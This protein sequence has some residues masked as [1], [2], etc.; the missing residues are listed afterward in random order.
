MPLSPGLFGL[1][2]RTQHHIPTAAGAGNRGPTC[3]RLEEAA[4]GQRM[5]SDPTISPP[6]TGAR[7]LGSPSFHLFTDAVLPSPCSLH[8]RALPLGSLT[9]CPPARVPPLPWNTLLALARSVSTG[10]SA[11]SGGVACTLQGH[12]SLCPALA[13]TG[14]L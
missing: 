7:D 2:R 4:T 3:L 5:R 1:Q 11:G 8:T 13:G 12:S 9:C 14:T 6:G 10:S